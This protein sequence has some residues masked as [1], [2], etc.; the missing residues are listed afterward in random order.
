MQLKSPFPAWTSH[1]LRRDTTDRLLTTCGTG[2]VRLSDVACSVFS[3]RSRQMLCRLHKAWTTCLPGAEYPI[4]RPESL[5]VFLTAALSVAKNFRQTIRSI[6]CPVS[7]HPAIE[8]RQHRSTNT[9]PHRSA[10]PRSSLTGQKETASYGFP[11][12]PLT[13]RTQRTH[14]IRRTGK[15]AEGRGRRTKRHIYRSLDEW[16]TQPVTHPESAMHPQ[17]TGILSP[18]FILT[19]RPAAFFSKLPSS[20]TGNEMCCFR[21]CST[22]TVP[23]Q[24]P[25]FPAVSVQSASQV[26]Y[27]TTVNCKAQPGADLR[28]LSIIVQRIYGGS[29][30]SRVSRPGVYTLK[31]R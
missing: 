16:Y 27:G 18:S 12:A 9:R 4:V 14:R 29:V 7:A 1:A 20:T 17:D 26:F 13:Q 24:R 11:P 23:V 25:F 22:R 15:G 5:P 31:N 21:A 8:I 6:H 19:R 3:G 2:R 28:C 10:A 30:S